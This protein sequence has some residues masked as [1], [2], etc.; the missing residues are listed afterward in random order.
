MFD[1]NQVYTINDFLSIDEWQIC[2]NESY[3]YSWN[4][5]G[6]SHDPNGRNFWKKDL[7]SDSVPKCD[8]VENIFKNKFE[9]L[10]NVKCWTQ[11]IYLNGQS[12]GQCGSFHKDIPETAAGEYVTLV[13]FPEKDWKP[14]WGGFTLII[15]NDKN[16]HTIYPK[17]NSA[18]VFNSK[19][20]H[21]GLEPTVHCT[22]QRISLAYK[23]KISRN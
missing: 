5:I 9:S 18:V 23:I 3:R 2:I 10:F 6:F 19:F 16:L 8:V 14:E 20:D 15:D 11:S 4:F 17:P 13:Y 7:W 12:H 21:V 1:I 22:T